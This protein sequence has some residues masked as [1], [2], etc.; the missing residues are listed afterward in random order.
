MTLQQQGLTGAKSEFACYTLPNINRIPSFRRMV[1]VRAK[2]TLIPVYN[3]CPKYDLDQRS[4]VRL[5][6]SFGSRQLELL[7]ERGFPESVRV[8]DDDLVFR[9]R[10][11]IL[12]V[13]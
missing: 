9:I 12:D 13:S 10:P 2:L 7:C 4:V 5:F 11:M 1:W 3:N 6:F 8:V